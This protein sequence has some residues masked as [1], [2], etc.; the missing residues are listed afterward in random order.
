MRIVAYQSVL[1]R[2]VLFVWFRF[3]SSQSYYRVAILSF[4]IV[5]CLY[6][7]FVETNK[8]EVAEKRMINA[9]IIFSYIGLKGISILTWRQ[10]CYYRTCGMYI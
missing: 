5:L 4:S 6:G 10:N 2:D 8:I 7:S 3:V 1:S 9:E